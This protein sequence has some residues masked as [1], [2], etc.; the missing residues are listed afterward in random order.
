M[1][2]TL[3]LGKVN[4]TDEWAMTKAAKAKIRNHW[5]CCD[6]HL[7]SSPLKNMN[8][9]QIQTNFCPQPLHQLHLPSSKICKKTP[10]MVLET[11]TVQAAIR[12]RKKA[13]YVCPSGYKLW[14]S[15][16]SSLLCG[17]RGLLRFWPLT[18]YTGLIYRNQGDC[19]TAQAYIFNDLLSQWNCI[20][21][22]GSGYGCTLAEAEASPLGFYLWWNGLSV[23][24]QL[25]V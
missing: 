10:D 16:L 20:C 17:S 9:M 21:S 3:F 1:Q 24:W 15:Y 25:Y 12:G 2:S 8:V 18:A 7:S 14:K 13:V 6:S 11:L 5:P 23:D 22:F 19:M 4:M